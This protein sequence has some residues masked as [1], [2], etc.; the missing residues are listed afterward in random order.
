MEAKNQINQ[1]QYNIK[2]QQFIISKY[3]QS[4]MLHIYPPKI[5]YR[6]QFLRKLFS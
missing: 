3:Q 6:I 2:E 5:V 4:G 1:Y